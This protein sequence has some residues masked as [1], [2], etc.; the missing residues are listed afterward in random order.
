MNRKDKTTF[1]SI[2]IESILRYKMIALGL[3]A[4]MIGAV[5][6]TLIPPLI[7]ES[8]VNQIADHEE[9]TLFLAFSYFVMLLA[10]AVF[11]SGKELMIT[12]FGQKSI[13]N[14]RHHMCRKLTR[15]PASYFTTHDSG[16]ITSR[17]VNDVDTMEDLFT[18]GVV[19]MVVDICKLGGILIVVWIKCTGLGILL[20]LITPLLYLLTRVFQ[21]KMLL[22]QLK[23]RQAIAR[24][25]HHV[26]ETITNIRMIHTF[27]KQDYMTGKYDQYIRSSYHA[28]EKSNLYDSIY[29]PIIIFS[30]SLVIAV[31]MIAASL[32]GWVGEYFGMQVG[33]AVAVIAYVGKVF[34]PLESIGM[35]IQNIQSAVAGITRIR[36]FLEEKDRDTTGS[37]LIE[38]VQIK[39]EKKADKKADKK[40]EKKDRSN[41]ESHGKI[42]FHDVS[43][44]YDK[45]HE[46]LNHLSFSI[47]RGEHVV[48]KGRTGAGKSTAFKLL[49]GLYEPSDGEISLSGYTPQFIPSDQRRK[50]YGYVEQNFCMVYGTVADQI[51]LFDDEISQ[52]QIETAARIAGIHDTIIK[53]DKQYETPCERN[54]FSEGQLQ[55]LS[56]ARAVVCNPEI[57]LLDETTAHLDTITE[58]QMMSA[59]DQAGKDRTV[60]SISH[61]SFA[62]TDSRVISI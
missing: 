29:S 9:V 36:E 60:F 22:A 1:T 20:L 54:L 35:E 18:D 52:L 24:V 56:I 12:V 47:D 55:L 45:N 50:T 28:V 57:L 46:V 16:S 15:L 26:P 37:S 51:S 19:S 27:G 31:L 8:I 40:V 5:T 43:F 23:N 59:L 4:T 7:L 21:K 53:M 62:D 30:S 41:I 17:L 44:C 10:G 2:V 38:S 48:L 6:F 58:K 14:I 42:V 33:T 61:R 39:T 34:S 11:D 32:G 49:L 25:N 3:L 13:R